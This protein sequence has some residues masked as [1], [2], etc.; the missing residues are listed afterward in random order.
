MDAYFNLYVLAQSG[1]AAGKTREL[2]TKITTLKITKA[3]IILLACYIVLGLIDKLVD[4]VSERIAKEWRLQVKQFIPFLRTM[5]LTITIVTLM[6]LFLNLS[7]ENVIAVTGAAAVALGF[8]FKDYASSI[9]AG[10][11]GIFEGSYRVGDYAP[12][13]IRIALK[14]AKIMER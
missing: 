9:I 12:R 14:L 2:L 5:I 8:A 3:I 6:N 10:I 4:W 11:V 1:D 7:P 13:G